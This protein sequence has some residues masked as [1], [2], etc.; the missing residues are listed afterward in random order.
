[1]RLDTKWHEISFEINTRDLHYDEWDSYGQNW[2]ESQ[3]LAILKW[4][5]VTNQISPSSF[6]QL[7][8]IHIKKIRTDLSPHP[9]YISTLLSFI[10]SPCSFS[11]LSFRFIPFLFNLL[12]H[13]LTFFQ[14]YFPCN[15]IILKHF[16]LSYPNILYLLFFP[17]SF[18]LLSLSFYVS[19]SFLY[20]T[21]VT[22]F[23]NHRLC[24]FYFLNQSVKS[25]TVSSLP[26]QV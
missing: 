15:F 9:K 24:L 17:S 1:M 18:F 26:L 19:L 14:F 5:G 21:L 20:L 25:V 4:W 13:T 23:A 8:L 10:H 11:F 6:K 2:I 7:Q 16:L 3:E 22:Y 12:I